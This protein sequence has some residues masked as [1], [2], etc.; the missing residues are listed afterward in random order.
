MTEYKMKYLVLGSH[1]QIGISLCE[2]LRDQGHEVRGFDIAVNPSHDLRQHNNPYLIQDLDWADFVFH[3]AW[4]VGGSGYLA[5]YQNTYDFISNNLKIAT[6]VFD[7]IKRFNKPCIFASSQMAAMSYSSYGLTKNLAE[8]MVRAMNSITVKF[9]NVYGIELDPEKTHVVTDFVNKAKSNRLIDMRTDGT[10]SRQMLHADDCSRALY[11]LSQ[12][13]EDLPRDR[14]Y[15]I[16]SFE[17]ST[18]LE[19]AEIVAEH[20]PGTKIQPSGIS[21]LVQ[22]DAKNEPD[23]YILQYWKPEIDLKLGIANIVKHMTLT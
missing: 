10:E 18:M 19:V 7:A 20:F 21:D 12:R 8:R 16:T 13:Y 15:H 5:R 6:T 22:K 1:G 23:T 4:D 14:E 2:Y 17:W 3:L 11:I 9:W